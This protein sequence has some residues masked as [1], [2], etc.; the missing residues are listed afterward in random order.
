MKISE[1][2]DVSFACFEQVFRELLVKYAILVFSSS[3]I[4][5]NKGVQQLV[6]EVEL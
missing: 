3:W 2:K 4:H 6:K 5:L 1:L